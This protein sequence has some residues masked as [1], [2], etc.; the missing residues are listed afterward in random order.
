MHKAMVA[1]ITN[2]H[3]QYDQHQQQQQ[4]HHQR[5]TIPKSVLYAPLL[6]KDDR[7][8]EAEEGCDG[9]IVKYHFHEMDV[10]M[11][12]DC[13]RSKLRYFTYDHTP[14]SIDSDAG[15][16]R[17]KKRRVDAVDKELLN[18]TIMT[19]S[20]LLPSTT[21]S[22]CR[23]VLP[24]TVQSKRPT[25][26]PRSPP[27]ATTADSTRAPP[28]CRFRDQYSALKRRSND[29]KGKRNASQPIVHCDAADQ[30]AYARSRL[31]GHDPR[32]ANT[33]V[34]RMVNF[35]NGVCKASRQLGS[36]PDDGYTIDTD[37]LAIILKK[38]MCRGCLLKLSCPHTKIAFGHYLNTTLVGNCAKSDIKLPEYFM[39]Y[40]V[41]DKLLR[42]AS[43]YLS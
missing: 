27:T 28:P 12:N 18:E 33:C 25:D 4:K 7:T 21:T 42:L 13:S 34:N 32:D 35:I 10:F 9:R 39:T 20:I 26:V 30:L 19:S 17:H 23:A 31:L 41:V 36:T 16:R 22:C 3:T 2:E 43:G 38:C 8:M 1:H 40:S 6:F 24:G 37:Q 15:T 5:S 11:C 29:R 14:Q